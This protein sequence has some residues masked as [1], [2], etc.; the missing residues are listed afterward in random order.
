M[1]YFVYDLQKSEATIE[2]AY[3]HEICV[4]SIIPSE[5][6]FFISVCDCAVD[7]KY[8]A[9]ISSLENLF[10]GASSVLSI[11]STK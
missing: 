2:V 5:E 11:I 6:V 8:D 3:I 1:C 10:K 9:Q 4:Y 7:A